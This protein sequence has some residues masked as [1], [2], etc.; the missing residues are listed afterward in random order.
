MGFGERWIRWIKFSLT[1]VKYSV[2]INR[3]PVGFVSPQK[4]IRQGDPLSPFLFII[5]MEGL[6][7][8]LDKARSTHKHA[9]KVN[10]VPDLDELEDNSEGHKFHLVKWA[11]VT[12]PKSLGGLG[13][14][15]LSK[16]NKSLLMKWNWRYGQEGTSLW[17]EIVKAKYGHLDNWSTRTTRAPHG[18]GPWKHIDSLKEVFQQEVSFKVGNGA[19]VKF[20]KDKWLG[21]FTIQETFPTLFHLATDPNSTVAQN[22]SNNT[23]EVRRNIQDWEIEEVLDLLG[24]LANCTM[25]IQHTDKLRWG[26]SKEGAYTV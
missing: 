1:T 6:S 16:H 18:V 14:R 24:R 9:E 3:S 15:D 2:L 5:A 23:W 26:T 19:H 10:V 12:Q 4:G 13:I 7:K 8:M 11:T 25:S 17:K 21:N 22:R 20:W